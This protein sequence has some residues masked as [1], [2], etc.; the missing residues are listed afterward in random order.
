MY[1]AGKIASCEDFGTAC[2]LNDNAR[3]H[4]VALLL[5]CRTLALMFVLLKALKLHDA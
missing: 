5:S 2:R 3:D 4:S 1:K